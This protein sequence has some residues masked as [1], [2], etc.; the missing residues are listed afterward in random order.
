MVFRF[1]DSL[2]SAHC[3]TDLPRVRSGAWVVTPQSPRGEKMTGRNS[4]LDLF[5][6]GAPLPI[7]AP[8][9]LSQYQLPPPLVLLPVLS[10]SLPSAIEKGCYSS[11]CLAQGAGK[12]GRLL[13]KFSPCDISG[14]GFTKGEEMVQGHRADI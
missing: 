6:P 2:S 11:L 7:P 1:L 12:G 14:K 10:P 4:S 5:P 8:L 9:S 3:C 13:Q